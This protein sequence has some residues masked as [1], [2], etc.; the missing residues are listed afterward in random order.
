MIL[1]LVTLRLFLLRTVEALGREFA[2]T[3]VAVLLFPRLD[4]LTLP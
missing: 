2:A 3:A 4:P 1:A